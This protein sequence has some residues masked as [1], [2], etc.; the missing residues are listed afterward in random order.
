MTE[1]INYKY[2]NSLTSQNPL[3]SRFIF[4]VPTLLLVSPSLSSLPHHSTS[5][6]RVFLFDF[7]PH[8][9]AAVVLHMHV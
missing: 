9:C 3:F 6:T 8:T 4:S 7:L 1:V 2:D 5:Q